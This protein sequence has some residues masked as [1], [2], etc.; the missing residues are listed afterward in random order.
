VGKEEFRL[1]LVRHHA[2]RHNAPFVMVNQ[3]GGNDEL[4]FDGRSYCVDSKGNLLAALPMFEESVVTVDTGANVEPLAFH[5][6]EEIESIYRALVLGTRDYLHKC[7]FERAIV[8]LSGGIDSA[9][10]LT[11]AARA[12]GPENVRAVTMPSPYSSQGSVDDSRALAENLGVEMDVVE[13]GDVMASYDR[14]LADGFAGRE[15]DATEEN[16]QAR[17]RGD[18]LMAF[19]N[20]FGCLALSTGNKSE[21][22]VGYCTL[23]GDMSGGLAVI[24]DV[25]K[26]TVYDLAEFVNRDGEIIPRASIDKAPS[27]ELKPNQKDQDSL[28]PYEVLDAIL[29]LYVE[30][31]KSAP[32]IVDRGYDEATVRWVV[33]AVRDSEYKRKQAAPGLKVT[34]KAF[35]IGRRF[36]IAARYDV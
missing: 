11:I 21:L 36:P 14:A 10:T 35:G 7:G 25:P 3:V 30:E 19:S 34:S 8:G 26:T 27:A 22:A 15:P 28:P 4:V 29:D 20:K 24:S 12:L 2:T 13:I 5:A 9:V 6:M 32:D 16:V 17:I 31:G 1:E 23:Y 18:I 33:G